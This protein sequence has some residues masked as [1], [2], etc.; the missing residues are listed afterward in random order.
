MFNGMGD[1]FIPQ[2]PSLNTA[3]HAPKSD[4]F[5]H[6]I[7]DIRNRRRVNLYLSC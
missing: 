3:F 4:S 2:V 7:R 5:G 6:H 1:A